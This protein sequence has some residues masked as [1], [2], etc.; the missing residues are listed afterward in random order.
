[1]TWLTP[2]TGLILAAAVIP[3]LVLLYFLKLRRR[4]QKIACTILWQRS[5]EDLQ[6]NAPFQKLRR[7]ILLLLQILA[8]ILLALSVM[9]PQIRAGELTG[10]KTIFLIDHSA[11]M[12]ATD[13][14]D[15]R[16]RLE[17]ARD[18]LRERIEARYSRG[19][20]GGDPGESMIIAFSDRAEIVARFTSSRQQLLRAVDRI[21]PTHGETKI[22]QA[23]ELARAYTTNIVDEM[24]EARPTGEPAALELYSDGQI[25][26]LDR[27]VLRGET[28]TYHA[29]G[30]DAPD[31]VAIVAMSVERPFARPTFI[32][33]FASLVNFNEHSVTCD[34]QVSVDGTALGIRTIEIPAGRFDE[35]AALFI[36]GRN[37]VVF[38]PFEQPRGA[39]IEVAN[40]RA[41]DLELDN[42][43][44]LSIPP[45]KRLEVALVA[46]KS[47]VIHS[48]LEGMPLERLDV[49]TARQF[50]ELVEH[51]QT[52][53]YDVIVL[54]SHVPE[55]MPSGRYLVFGE[56]PPVDGLN[57][58]GAGGR[59]LILNIRDEHPAMR[60]VDLNNLIIQSFTALQPDDDVRILAEG[61][62]GPAIIA[63]DRAGFNMI[64]VTNDVLDSNWPMLRSF[65]T[66]IFNAVE[67]LGHIGERLVS[68]S[69][70][71]GEALTARLP[72]SAQEI[73]LTL[74]TGRSERLTPPE[75]A[76]M[77]WGPIR[78]TG[79][80]V[81]S[82]TDAVR[83][84]QETRAYTVNL[85]SETEGNVRVV[86]ALS[87]GE[88]RIAGRRAG[89][90]RYTALWPYALLLCLVLLMVEWW[91]YHRKLTI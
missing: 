3:P 79:P 17:H 43:A 2:L 35:A 60:H 44:Q 63:V 88:D 58:Y 80:H 66:F 69:L 46:P 76:R 22:E 61:S 9:Q 54:D 70:R 62:A 7:N 86:D 56:A 12:N 41:D 39:V 38:A 87:F 45:A 84:E 53:R 83:G 5:I 67:H 51:Q 68:E 20:L 4:T 16:P 36:P 31:N 47:F 24:G 82:W 21:Q 13:T 25:A 48:V 29:F 8:L 57:A 72:A 65:V 14:G 64:Y 33:V 71:P 73:E 1:M 28:L 11:S 89:D 19:L 50:D 74:P 30:S 81:L 40:L 78:L 42:L 34:V 15:G 90:G 91:V 55:T 75:P 6:A 49:L 18:L 85:F 27:Q 77:S 52:D 32:E 10:G 37:N 26:D 59:Q 23:L